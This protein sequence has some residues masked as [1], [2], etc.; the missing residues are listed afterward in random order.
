MARI[1]RPLLTMHNSWPGLT[2]LSYTRPGRLKRSPRSNSICG[3]HNRNSYWTADR[4]RVRGWPHS[5]LCMLHDHADETA[6]HLSLG[7]SFAKEVWRTFSRSDDKAASFAS[8]T[9]SISDWW[10]KTLGLGRLQETRKQMTT[11]TYV[12]WNLWK[13]R[14]RRTFEEKRCSPE[15]VA[16]MTRDEISLFWEGVT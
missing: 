9:T 1:P 7:C 4:L 10:R 16:A 2:G 15:T 3:L 12:V 14:N 5:D 11:A 8:S 13:E 6:A